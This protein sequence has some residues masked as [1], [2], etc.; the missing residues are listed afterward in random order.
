MDKTKIL[1]KQLFRIVF[2]GG[3]IKVTCTHS[4]NTK[5]VGVKT[6]RDKRFKHDNNKKYTRKLNRHRS[7]CDTLQDHAD[8]LKNDG[9][10]LSSDFILELIK[11]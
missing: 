9:E 10:R 1:T 6:D 11:S 5:H 7:V 2:D 3:I 4:S 8:I